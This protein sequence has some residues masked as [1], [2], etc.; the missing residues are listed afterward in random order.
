M[1]TSKC[2]IFFTSQKHCD[3]YKNNILQC[4]QIKGQ[5]QNYPH[6]SA[7]TRV[8]IINTKISLHN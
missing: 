1:G 4:M 6:R 2:N 7:G 3:I 8:K 5:N